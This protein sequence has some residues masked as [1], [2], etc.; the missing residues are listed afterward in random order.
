[1]VGHG[2]I[3]ILILAMAL[4]MVAL[5]PVMALVNVNKENWIDYISLKLGECQRGHLA[6]NVKPIAESTFNAHSLRRA[7]SLDGTIPRFGIQ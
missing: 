2:R 3:A 4:A 5:M 7:I 6:S 1:M